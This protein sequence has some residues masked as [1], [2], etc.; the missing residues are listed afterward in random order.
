MYSECISDII[1]FWFACNVKHESKTC[2]GTAAIHN[3]PFISVGIIV[4]ILIACHQRR[5]CNY[6]IRWQRNFS[7]ND[8]SA[9]FES[10]RYFARISSLIVLELKTRFHKLKHWMFYV[11][12]EFHLQFDRIFSE[13]FASYSRRRTPKLHRM[14]HVVRFLSLND[15]KRNYSSSVKT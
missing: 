15:H 7:L 9:Q 6:V 14:A 1:Y 5:S 8:F 10:I 11:M 13:F 3:L 12:V 2:S 4:V